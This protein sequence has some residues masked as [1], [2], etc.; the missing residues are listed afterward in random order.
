MAKSEQVVGPEVIDQ[1]ETVLLEQHAHSRDLLKALTGRGPELMT[2]ALRSNG[3][4]ALTM[5]MGWLTMDD[6]AG[7][8][9]SS[10]MGFGTAY[11]FNYK[12]Q[13]SAEV[14]KGLL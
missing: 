7:Y 4:I 12:V 3:G 5:V 9:L 6:R 10:P 8:G 2:H 1:A 13:S 14:N 11:E